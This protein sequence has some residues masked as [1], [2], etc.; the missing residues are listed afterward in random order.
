MT[1][2][3]LSTLS[4]AFPLQIESRSGPRF[5]EVVQDEYTTWI[6][7]YPMKSKETAAFASRVRRLLM[8]NSCFRAG[9]LL[10]DG[11]SALLGCAERE[12]R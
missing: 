3:M 5:V 12:Y 9:R 8:M 1:G 10:T 7:G 6:Q 4:A 2:V 11:I